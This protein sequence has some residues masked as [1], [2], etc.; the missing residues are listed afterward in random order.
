M[1]A[2]PEKRVREL[3]ARKAEDP[4]GWSEADEHKLQR[5]RSALKKARSRAKSGAS[6]GPKGTGRVSSHRDKAQ[7]PTR[8][9]IRAAHR[10]A[11]FAQQAMREGSRQTLPWDDDKPPAGTKLRKLARH[12]WI[13][14]QMRLGVS[15]GAIR[16][17]GAIEWECHTGTIDRDISAISRAHQRDM[18]KRGVL[19][20]GIRAVLERMALRGQLMDAA[21]QRA[22]ETL[23]KYLGEKMSVLRL[24]KLGIKIDEHEAQLRELEVR[25]REAQIKL[26]EARAK[27]AEVASSKGSGRSVVVLALDD[28]SP[29]A[30]AF[31]SGDAKL[32]QFTD[33]A[34]PA[35]EV[36]DL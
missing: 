34:P 4:E 16:N 1:A 11:Q 7:N 12:E 32:E 25:R 19:G 35:S 6:A 2:R 3:E 26:T 36:G 8:E 20:A 28:G 18:K 13:A 30:G 5:A 23:L 21:G 22:D 15:I 33:A 27:L 31:E 24:E 29:L 9:R 14:Q 17:E 10:V